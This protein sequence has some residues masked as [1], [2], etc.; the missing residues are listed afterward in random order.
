MGLYIGSTPIK[1]LDVGVTSTTSNLQ[2][3]SVTP[4]KS[5]QIITYDS[6]YTGLSKV[7]VE[8]IPNNYI[9]TEDG[10]ITSSD[11]VQ[12]K[13]GYANGQRIEGILIIQKYYTGSSAPSSN[14]GNN[15]DIYLQK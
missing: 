8:A 5:S 15:G 4:T 6:G 11:V 7:T 12:G 13:V 10:D 2:E 9:E 14:L 1:K 3:K